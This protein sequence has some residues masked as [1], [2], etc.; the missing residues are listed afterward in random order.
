MTLTPTVQLA[1]GA[2]YTARLDTTVQAADG[3][4]LASAVA[5]SFT[6]T[7]AACPC[8]LFTQAAAPAT[9]QNPTQDGRTGAGPW[10]SSS[11]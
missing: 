1:T 9:H 6:A 5:W 4:A 2:S 11:V 7:T 10:S 3:V 8:S